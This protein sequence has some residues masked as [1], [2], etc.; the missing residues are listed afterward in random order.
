[1][2]GETIDEYNN[3]LNN[4]NG[5]WR[6]L[7]ITSQIGATNLLSKLNLNNKFSQTYLSIYNKFG[8]QEFSPI[9]DSGCCLGREL[10]NEKINTLLK[11]E[12]ML[13]S[14]INKGV[15]EI[16]WEGISKKPKHFDLIHNLEEKYPKTVKEVIARVHEK[17]NHSKIMDLI[18]N[19]DSNLPLNLK[20]YKLEEN[21]KELIYKIV[22]LRL[23]KLSRI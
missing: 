13:E 19:I 10:E 8:R 20:N 9:Y 14:Y 4:S 3:K 12:V 1:L 17:T 6:S 15:S 21:R 18:N 7:Y 23:D 5:F 16:R 2:F 11:D 22:S